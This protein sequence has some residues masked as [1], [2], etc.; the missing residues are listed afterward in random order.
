MSDVDYAAAAVTALERLNAVYNG[1]STDGWEEKETNDS[2]MRFLHCF[3]VVT[4]TFRG[5]VAGS[6]SW[7]IDEMI[8]A[9]ISV[10]VAPALFLVFTLRLQRLN[11]LFD[12]PWCIISELERHHRSI[13]PVIRP[14]TPQMQETRFGRARWAT[15]ITWSASVAI[16]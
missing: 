15:T 12:F 7:F 10:R 16:T 3:A 4:C 2:G 11:F 13:Q 14:I 6:C 5:G 1:G 9:G 8:P